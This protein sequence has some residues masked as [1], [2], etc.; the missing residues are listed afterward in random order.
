MTQT[1][2]AQPQ[3]LDWLLLTLIIL[4]GGSSFSMI[5][6]AV[7]SVPPAIIAVGRI[8]VGAILMTAL[9]YGTGRRLPPFLT[10]GKGLMPTPEW[11]AMIGVGIVGTT[12][13]FFLY[14]WAQQYVPSGL[15]GIYM[16]LMPIWT[17][18]LAALFAGEPLTG[19]RLAGFGVGFLGVIILMFPALQAGEAGAANNKAL[20]AQIGLVAATLFYAMSAVLARRAPFIRPR[21]FSAGA[22]IA[23]AISATPA[24]LFIDWQRESWTLAGILNTIGLGIFPTGINAFLIIY[25]IQRCGAGFMSFS[26]YLTPIWAIILGAYLFNEQLGLNAFVALAIVIAGLGISQSGNANSKPS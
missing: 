16:A 22:L 23:A 13:T 1:P 3:K 15:A 4:I 2:Q 20:W 24:L 12:V 5:K 6:G 11:Q 10:S 25:L 9:A 26:N 19:R 14:P 18:A 21:V 17:L 7:A 8:W